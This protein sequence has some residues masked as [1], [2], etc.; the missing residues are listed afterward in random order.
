ME[1][2]IED[3]VVL[4]DAESARAFAATIRTEVTDVSLVEK[5]FQKTFKHCPPCS[6]MPVYISWGYAG[7][8]FRGWTWSLLNLP[9]RTVLFVKAAWTQVAHVFFCI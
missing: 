5:D 4:R 6:R 2:M 7:I 9:F 8:I 3:V 1:E